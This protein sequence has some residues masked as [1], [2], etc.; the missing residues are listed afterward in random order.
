MNDRATA[1]RGRLSVH[2]PAGSGTVLTTTLPI[3]RGV[4]DTA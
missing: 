2:S 1:V 4:G 3:S